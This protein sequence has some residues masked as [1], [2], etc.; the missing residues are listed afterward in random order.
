MLAGCFS[1]PTTSSSST[2]STSTQNLPV[3]TVVNST[4]YT[5]VSLY[6]SP[7]STDDWEEDV[8]ANRSSAFR[9]GDTVRVTLAY[10]LSRYNRYDFKLVDTDGDSYLKWNVL[11]TENSTV[12]FVF[13]DILLD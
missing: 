9:N 2:S 13:D 4:G 7:V 3:V 10:P 6:L 5:G 1:M 8:L 11:L 12:V